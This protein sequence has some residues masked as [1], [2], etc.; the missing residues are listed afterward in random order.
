MKRILILASHPH[1]LI[2]FRG[3][4]IIALRARGHEIIT[5][6][7]GDSP[8]TDCRLIEFGVRRI[9]I[10]LDRTGVGLWSDLNLIYSLIRLMQTENP[11]M[12]IAYTIKPVIYGSLAAYFSGVQRRVAIITGLGFVFSKSKSLFHVL[13]RFV[14]IMLYRTAMLVTDTV[15]FQNTDDVAEFRNEGLLNKAQNICQINGSG[16]NLDHY[17][18]KPHQ[19]LRINFLM[20]GRLLKSKGVREYVEAAQIVK[21]IYPNIV[22]SLVGWKD[23]NPDAI[24][25][26]ELSCWVDSGIVEYLSHLRDVRGAIANCSV[27]VLPSYRE[28]TPRTVLEAMAMGRAIITTDTPGCRETVLEGLNGF[29]VPARSPEALARAMMKFIEMP[30][31]IETM[32]F[33]SRKIAEDKFDVHKVNEVIIKELE[34]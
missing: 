2:N 32:G 34:L 6:A 11:D 14:A 7:P 31:L 1:S 25:D 17:S 23:K 20:I 5:A 9:K 10:P 24:T 8:E 4:L 29:L 22:F 30:N 33:Y 21:N 18:V 16:V 28:G 27:F 3:D 12:L 13:T 19:K 26:A 15:F